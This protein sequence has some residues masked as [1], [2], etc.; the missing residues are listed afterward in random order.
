MPGATFI[1]PA[2]PGTETG[3]GSSVSAGG[4]FNADGFGD[5]LIGAPDFSS[6]YDRCQSGRSLSC[7]TEP[8]ARAAAS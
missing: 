6:S 2:V 4:D 7:S 5:I 3:L 1:G 8:R